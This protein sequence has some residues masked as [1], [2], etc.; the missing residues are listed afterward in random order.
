MRSNIERARGY[1]DRAEELRA[2]TDLSYEP[3]AKEALQRLAK[4]YDALAEKLDPAAAG[5]TASSVMPLRF[6]N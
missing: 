2:L 1:R 3:F 4:E 5:D 6:M